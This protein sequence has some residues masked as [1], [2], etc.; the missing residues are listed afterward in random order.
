M[1]TRSVALS[2][3]LVTVLVT[4]D[5]FRGSSRGFVRVRRV[6]K[7]ASDLRR[8]RW[9]TTMN[10][11]HL[12]EGLVGFAARGGSNPP[13]DTEPY[14]HLRDWLPPV[15]LVS[16]PAPPSAV[17]LRGVQLSLHGHQEYSVVR[18]FSGTSP[19]G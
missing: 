1:C 15:P 5:S 14:E 17:N 4:L 3:L 19:F 16:P 10:R 8:E 6:D 18:P 13:S 9:R 2:G 7:R 11:S 12:L